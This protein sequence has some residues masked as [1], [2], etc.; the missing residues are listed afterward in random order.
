M[1]ETMKDSLTIISTL[2]FWLLWIIVLLVTVVIIAV[3]PFDYKRCSNLYED[4]KYDIIWWCKVKYGSW[5]I[6]ERLYEKAF[7]QNV[8]VNI[9]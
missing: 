8:N 2:F 7:V 9:K 6:S 1:N 3:S 5:Y 4:T